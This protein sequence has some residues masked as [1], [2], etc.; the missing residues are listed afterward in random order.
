MAERIRCV[1]LF[2]G[3]GGMSLGFERAGFDV[4]AG[5]DNWKAAIRV[6]EM[7]FNHP[8]IEQDLVNVD[9]AVKKIRDYTPD[10]IIGGPPCQDFSTAGLQDETRGRAVLSICY[11]Q[12]VSIVRPKY[13]VMENVATIRNTKSFQIVISN[14]RAAG[15]GLTQMVLDAAYCGVPQ[16]RKRMFVVGVLGASDGFLDEELKRNLAQEPMSIHDYLG[17]SLGID[18]YFRVPTNYN[19][20]GVFSVYEPSMTIRAVD[21]PIPKGYKGHPNDPVPVEKVRCLTPKERSYIQTFPESFQFVGGKSDINS[22][23]GNAVPVNLAKYVGTAL[24]RY[25]MTEESREND[26]SN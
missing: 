12:I 8:V 26:E 13:F 19:R 1:D 20:R 15:Y 2:C 4:V 5:F 17:D 22:M 3:C 9:E 23:I 7:N 24:M 14:F 21:R 25:K 11:S 6:Y 16:T 10:L 18:Y